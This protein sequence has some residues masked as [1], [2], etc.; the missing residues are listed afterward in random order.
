MEKTL[1][2]AMR[3][4][5]VVFGARTM[6]IWHI[7]AATKRNLANTTWMELC[8]YL[9]VF[10]RWFFYLFLFYIFKWAVILVARAKHN[11][12]HVKMLVYNKA[13][14]TYIIYFHNPYTIHHE[15]IIGITLDGIL[16]KYHH[17]HINEIETECVIILFF[18]LARSM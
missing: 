16:K 6:L 5:K 15:K 18:M 12:H 11:L 4:F 3:W 13:C 10:F 7:A 1:S 8:I 14:N 9:I 17:D 2:F